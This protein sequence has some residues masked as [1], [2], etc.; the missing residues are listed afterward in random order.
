MLR[1]LEIL[2]KHLSDEMFEMESKFKEG[3]IFRYRIMTVAFRI[4]SDSIDE[5]M[6]ANNKLKLLLAKKYGVTA[7]VNV[8][9]APGFNL[10]QPI[11]VLVEVNDNGQINKVA[12]NEIEGADEV[13][14]GTFDEIAAELGI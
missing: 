1:K 6:Y 14:V 9:V 11:T 8:A 2:N 5:S 7:R 13:W 12:V 3:S 10:N 4:D